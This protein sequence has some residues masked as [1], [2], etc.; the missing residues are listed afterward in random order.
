MFCGSSPGTRPVFAKAAGA[1]GAELGRRG[2]GL[3]YGGGDRGL[4][5]AVARAAAAAGSAVTGVTVGEVASREGAAATPEIG[6]LLVAPSLSERKRIM[7]ERAQAFVM[8][9]GGFG[10]LD[11][12]FEMVTWN[13][14]R[15]HDK[16]CG[17]LDVDGYFGP[18]L[19]LVARAVAEGFIRADHAGALAVAATPSALIDELARRSGPPATAG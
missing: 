3:V 16:P 1:L 6:E 10:T 4:M 12:L 15:I 5:G 14:L 2:I 17:I 18:L 8:L 13:Q 7:A 9:P 19:D 11:E